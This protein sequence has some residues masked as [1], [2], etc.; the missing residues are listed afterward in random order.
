VLHVETAVHDSGWT[1]E[2]AIPWTT[3]RLD[4]GRPEQVWGV[5]FLRRIRRKNEEAYWAPLERRR[6]LYTM[7]SAGTLEGLEGVRPGRNFMLKPYVLGTR[8]TGSLVPLP[9]RRAG[10]DGGMDLK[11][12]VTSGLTLDLTYNTDFSQVEVDQ[13]QVNLTRFS[14]FF[15]EKRDF[16]LENSGTFDFGDVAERYVRVGASLRDLTLFHSRRIGLTPDG[17][18]IPLAGGVRMTGRAGAYE[19][20][21]LEMQTEPLGDLPAENFAVA[22]VRR[23]VAGRADVGAMLVNRM[24]TSGLERHR[25]L[26]LGADANVR[27]HRHLMV[28]SYL[29]ATDE[30][31]RDGDNLAARLAYAFRNPTWESTGFLKHVGEDFE[32]GAGFVRRRG[33]RHAYGTVGM[34]RRPGFLAGVQNVNPYLEADHVT[35]PGVGL[36]TRTGTLG[37]DV[38]FADGGALRMGA[39]D[40]FERLSLPFRVRADAT[41]PPGDYDFRD[42]TLGYASSRGR[43]LSGDASVSAGGFYDGSLA[44]I[45]LGGR[46]RPNYRWMLNLAASHNRI[47]LPDA[48]FTADVVGS[49]VSY[50]HSTRLYSSAFVQYNQALD[51][52][53]TNL[54]LNVVHAPLSDLFLVLTER[55]DLAREEV[56]ERVVSLKLTRMLAF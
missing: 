7:S 31:G 24:A 6:V 51:Q 26:S 37:L 11:W 1:V 33:M 21:L 3:L 53:V 39:S 49:R 20:G 8:P 19:I 38:E 46:W 50:A 12:G 30:P 9:D 32:P 55:R 43:S 15:P 34:H 25:N 27:L 52:L 5:N 2:M 56:V 48:R 22:R 16:F 36:A 42:L 44:S 4:P 29:A 14:L 35:E 17:R 23:N 45:S 13:E 10:Y 47:E 28:H 54:R 40:R 18:P 41:V